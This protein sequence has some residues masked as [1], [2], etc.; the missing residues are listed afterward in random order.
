M[1][2]ERSAIFQK[3]EDYQHMTLEEL[4]DIT[5]NQK[6]NGCKWRYRTLGGEQC[7]VFAVSTFL[8]RKYDEIINEA[9]TYDKNNKNK[10]NN[11]NASKKHS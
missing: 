8:N 2:K 6:C 7:I 1:D 4:S 9:I 11:K 3:M 10:N 5:C